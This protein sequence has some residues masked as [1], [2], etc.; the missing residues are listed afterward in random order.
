MGC[1]FLYFTLKDNYVG[2]LG[3]CSL[4]LFFGKI[5]ANGV[6]WRLNQTRW[7]NYEKDLEDAVRFY[8]QTGGDNFR[9]TADNE[10][11]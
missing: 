4:S 6:P 10:D 3:F 8:R 7:L 1:D 2:R 5:V 11:T 9:Y